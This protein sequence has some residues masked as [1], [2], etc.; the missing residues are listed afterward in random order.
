[1]ES[2][3]GITKTE[4]NKEQGEQ[5]T[6]TFDIM[7]IETYSKLGDLNQFQFDRIWNHPKA[8]LNWNKLVVKRGKSGLRQQLYMKC[9]TLKELKQLYGENKT[10]KV[11]AKEE[12]KW[13][14]KRGNV[15]VNV[16]KES[17][18]RCFFIDKK[19]DSQRV[20]PTPDIHQL[21][22]EEEIIVPNNSQT[23]IRLKFR[24]T[25]PPPMSIEKVTINKKRRLVFS[26]SKTSMITPIKMSTDTKKIKSQSSQQQKES[27]NH[28]F[29][30][31]GSSNPL[32][33]NNHDDIQSSPLQRNRFELTSQTSQSTPP[34]H[35]ISLSYDPSWLQEN[36]VTI[37][38][39]MK[40]PWYS[41]FDGTGN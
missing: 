14:F 17:C 11:N 36:K 21:Q 28:I 26:S 38:N 6:R 31:Q 23:P 4:K 25:Q 32:L 30:Q 35:A 3:Q 1:M 18:Q 8:T 7:E 34:I 39:D 2:S 40:R 41:T 29:S 37:K 15:S 13:D 19:V 20:E 22:E 9:T 27:W 5:R 24:N 10:W 16:P 33:N 12:F